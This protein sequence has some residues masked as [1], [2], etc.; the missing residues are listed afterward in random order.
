MKKANWLNVHK[1]V[2]LSAQLLGLAFVALIS[3]PALVLVCLLA[4]IV[5]ILT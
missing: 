3:I 5:N 1:D 2:S 4:L